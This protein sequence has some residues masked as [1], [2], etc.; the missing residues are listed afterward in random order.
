MIVRTLTSDSTNHSCHETRYC[1]LLYKAKGGTPAVLLLDI[2]QQYRATVV[3]VQ[4]VWQVLGCAMVKPLGAGYDGELVSELAAFCVH[5]DYRGSG[6]GD[7]L[8]AY[9]GT[10]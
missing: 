8:L 3:M 6:R 9:L 5:P 7:S 1:E 2:T 10:L 4:C